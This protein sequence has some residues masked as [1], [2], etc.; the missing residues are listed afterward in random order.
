M[1]GKAV[2]AVG[3]G[4]PVVLVGG[5]IGGEGDDRVVG[6]DGVAVVGRFDFFELSLIPV[7]G[8]EGLGSEMIEVVDV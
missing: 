4:A 6:S 5:E 8:G 1:L 3:P 2:S 7:Q